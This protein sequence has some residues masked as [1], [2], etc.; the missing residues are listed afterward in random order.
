MYKYN[1]DNGFIEGENNKIK[2]RKRLSYGIKKFD[3]LKKLSLESRKVIKL[4]LAPILTKSHY[5]F[6][7]IHLY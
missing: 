5:F 7:C 2:V 6:I 1:I 3:S 4:F